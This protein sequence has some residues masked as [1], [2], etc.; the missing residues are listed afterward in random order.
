MRLPSGGIDIFYVDESTDANVL[1]MSAVAIP[2]IREVEGTW[3]VVWEDHLSNIREWRKRLSATHRIPVR[4]EL[5][6]AK[7][8]SGRGRYY[9]GKH[10]LQRPAA[11]RA[12]RNAMSDLAWLP[13]TSII[14][15]V[16][17]PKSNLYGHTRLEAA[18]YA[19]LQRM[20]TAC[21]KTN[22]LGMVFFDEGHGEYR[23]LYRKAR[24]YLPTGSD[25]GDWGQGNKSK[26]IPLD[27][28]V[29]DA[30]IK[31]SQHSL[32]IQLADLVSFAG[33]AKIR[34][35][36]KLLA[37]WQSALDLET[38]YDAIPVAKLNHYASRK[39]PLGI[40]RL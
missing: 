16:G 23:K 37:P 20:R 7:L 33:L 40:V 15:V 31:Q 12:Y 24:V 21:A 22:R 39:D 19:L 36:L 1:V 35:E 38:L 17:T 14:T 29:K 3:T 9:L 8:S 30:N 34:G 28:F 2:F 4:K 5:K 18:L 13:G 26:N 32:F 6:A 27:N 11:A 10:Q 25:Q